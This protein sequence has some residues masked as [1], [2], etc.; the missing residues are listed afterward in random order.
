MR[1]FESWFEDFDIHKVDPFTEVDNEFQIEAPRVCYVVFDK[2]NCPVSTTGYKV[3][4]SVL[5]REVMED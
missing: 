1:S 3:L 4:G 2:D 5:M